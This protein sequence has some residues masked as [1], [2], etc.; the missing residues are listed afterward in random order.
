MP[1][2]IFLVAMSLPDSGGPERQDLDDC[3][4]SYAQLAALTEA[5]P[6]SIALASL[7]ACA[8]ERQRLASKVGDE[9]IP[10]E[11]QRIA[12]RVIIFVQRYR[13]ISPL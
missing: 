5:T 2:L 6:V 10:T 11:E 13:H 8:A 12:K 4:S 7:K 1:L 3:T 9:R